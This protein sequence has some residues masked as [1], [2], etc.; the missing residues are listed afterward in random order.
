MRRTGPWVCTLLIACGPGLGSSASEA[1]DAGSEES[2]NGS[3][4]ESDA[5]GGSSES[6]AT[7]GSTAGDGDGSGTSGDGDG[8]SGDGDGTSGD[9]DGDATS[10]SG[11]GD[12]T[13]ISGDGD[14]T[15]STSVTA[16][17]DGDGDGTSVT[18]TG[19][20]TGLDWSWSG[21]RDWGDGD[22]CIDGELG[23]ACLPGEVCSDPF[24][25]DATLGTCQ[26]EC[27][28]DSD[29][30]GDPS[31]VGGC[32]DYLCTYRPKCDDGITCTVDGYD[33]GT[34]TCSFDTTACASCVPYRLE[35]EEQAM[36]F[37]QGAWSV[38]GGSVLSGGQAVE[39]STT[40]DS[41]RTWVLGTDI[42]VGY[43]AGPNRGVFT[44]AVDGMVTAVVDAYQ[45][46]SFSFQVPATVAN[47]LPFGLHE[48][49]I[50]Q[51]GSNPPSNGSY[52]TIDFVDVL[53]T[54]P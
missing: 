40:G 25:C 5:A 1:A 12:G 38:P 11:D 31:T 49:V 21:D 13:S 20:G 22:G 14:G 4:A 39:S 8:T 15:G 51:N 28:V 45:A 44:A 27:W 52:V 9:G 24:F 17:G 42:V 2:S 35:A 47:G 34:D 33:V 43:E 32:D 37:R 10:A 18:L 3:Q 19:D 50:T 53:C 23:C 16:T 54:A 26:P 6:S 46:G 7:E 36:V 30:V 41:L 48:V 29:C